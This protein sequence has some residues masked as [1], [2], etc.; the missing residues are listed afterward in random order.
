[1]EQ[2]RRDRTMFKSIPMFNV[3]CM[4][5]T[6][7]SISVFVSVFFIVGALPSIGEDAFTLIV[8][9]VKA[10]MVSGSDVDIVITLTNVSSVDVDCKQWYQR[11]L[12]RAYH[13]DVVTESGAAAPPA[14]RD[15]PEVPDAEV[16]HVCSLKPGAS[17][18]VT[19]VLSDGFDFGQPGDYFIS[20]SRRSGQDSEG[21]PTYVRSNRTRITVVAAGP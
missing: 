19:E 1:M 13:Y 21:R 16:T 2:C 3:K 15:H 8:R 4:R 7:R 9:P 12:D 14:F 6:V 5:A 18:T 17:M 10:Q 11:N 20:V